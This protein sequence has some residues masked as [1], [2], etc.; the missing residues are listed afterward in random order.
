[1]R[2]NMLR[3]CCV[4]CVFCC[5]CCFW[6]NIF[7]VFPDFGSKTKTVGDMER[8]PKWKLSGKKFVT[9]WDATC[10]VFVAFVA[11]FVV[12][13]VF[14]ATFFGFSGFS[15]YSS[16]NSYVFTVRTA[17]EILTFLPLILLGWMFLEVSFWSRIIR[18]FVVPHKN[19]PILI[20]KLDF[21][22]VYYSGTT[23]SFIRE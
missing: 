20:T 11:F 1:M 13:V 15:L 2:C 6:N 22:L 5:F 7:S 12:F 19:G 4:C 21:S 14:G 9:W 23:P 18:C 8:C 10:C 3:F 17:A 16:R